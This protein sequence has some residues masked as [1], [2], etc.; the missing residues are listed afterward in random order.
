MSRL[1]VLDTTILISAALKPNGGAG[2]L[3]QYAR[4]GRIRIAL[5][6]KLHDELESRLT[7]RERFRKFLTE[8]EAQMYADALALIG[9]WHEDRP[10]DELPQIC[11]DP[12]DNFVIVLYQDTDAVMLVSNDDD[13][14][15]LKYPNLIVGNPGRALAAIDYHHEWGDQY[16][17][18][19]F[20]ESLLQ[21]E[22]EGSA[23]IIAAYTAFA[24]VVWDNAPELLPSV[25]VPETHP[26]FVN[27]FNEVR[28]MLHD[29]AMTTRPHFASPEV[30]YVKLPPTPRQNVR[31][32]GETE[33]PAGT[34]FATMQHCPDLVDPPGYG[35]ANWRVFGIG[36]QWPLEQIPPRPSA[37]HRG[38]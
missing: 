32:T 19:S 20:E 3:L 22:A 28:A 9:E 31:V 8:D 6:P 29:R 13:I 30:A 23:G 10:D 26:S 27:D 21:I 15:A 1:F 4:E 24:N 17:P 37:P 5:S 25:V 7:T 33:L 12:D 18:G 2:K 35:F 38:S 14:L 16:V 36:R 11:R 34:I